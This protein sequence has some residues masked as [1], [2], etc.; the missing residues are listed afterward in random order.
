MNNQ[1]LGYNPKDATSIWQ[2]SA[3]LLGHTLREFIDG[4]LGKEYTGKGALGQ[5]VEEIY[6]HLANNSRAEADFHSAGVEL[7]CTP[8]KHGRREALLIKERLV[9]GMINYCE[10][11]GEDFEESHFYTKCQLMLLLFYLHIQ[12]VNKLDLEFLISLLWK[13]PDKDLEI[14]RQDYYTI[15]N[16]VKQGLAH[17]ISEGDTLYLGAC[18]KGVD[19]SSVTIQPYSATLAPTRAFCLKQSYMSTILKWIIETK[20]NHLNMLNPELSSLVSLQALKEES[21]ET[22]ILKRYFKY[23]GQGYEKIAKSLKVDLSKNPKN[24]FA[25]IA[26]AIGTN[27]K[28]TNINATE[29]FLKSG[30][31]M[32]AIR[33]QANGRIKESMAFE[34]INYKEVY[35]EEN[36]WIDSRCYDIFTSRFL[37]VIFREQTQNS[38]D[39]VLDKIFFWTMPSADLNVAEEY[40]KNIKQCVNDNHIAPEYFWKIGDHKLFHVRPKGRDVEDLAPNPHGGKAR[41]YCYWF[42]NEYITD[43]VNKNK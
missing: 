21:F 39:Y 13:F 29:E 17:E 9:C 8:L 4:E 43:I 30:L 15:V 41:K 31:M 35:K 14:I 3:G 16:K 1:P 37:F 7:K 27:G 11:V 20:K 5:M 23:I 42:N 25:M 33:V 26:S 22:I 18:R 10:L 40:W 38:G 6:F 19:G 34:N 24:K 2:Y 12:D 36:E 28:R 32:K